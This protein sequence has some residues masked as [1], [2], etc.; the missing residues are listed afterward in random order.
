MLLEKKDFELL[1]LG[2]I[3]NKLEEQTRFSLLLAL[4]VIN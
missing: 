1:N 3:T 4:K 2:S